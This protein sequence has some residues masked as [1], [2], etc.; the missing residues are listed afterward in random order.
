[1]QLNIEYLFQECFKYTKMFFVKYFLKLI[2]L[3]YIFYIKHSQQFIDRISYICT[4]VPRIISVLE[5]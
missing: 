2:F 4:Y 5:Y 3:N 1:M